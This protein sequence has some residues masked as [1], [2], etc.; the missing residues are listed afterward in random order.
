MRTQLGVLTIN[1][2]LIGAFGL[3]F[4]RIASESLSRKL[5]GRFSVPL[6]GLILASIA[7]APFFWGIAKG[8]LKGEAVRRLWLS[9]SS[10]PLLVLLMVARAA[11]FIA[12]G[13]YLASRFFPLGPGF[14]V[15]GGFIAGAVILISKNLEQVYERFVQRFLLSLSE[16]EQAEAAR[17]RPHPGES[18]TPRL[19]V[20]DGHIAVFD[21]TLDSP[22]VGRTLIELQV[23]ERF[24]A[25]VTLIE[26]EDRKLPAPSA[27]ER[28]Y[29]GDRIHAIGSDEQLAALREFLEVPPPAHEGDESGEATFSL[30]PV[31]VSNRSPFVGLSIRQCGIR[32]KARGLV[33]GVEREGHRIPNPS[34][35]FHIREGDLLWI[36]GETEKVIE[37]EGLH[38]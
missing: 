33:V 22:A 38:V 5:G 14:I 4:E 24:G 32:E 3:F 15:A 37:L 8:G 7:S 28:V 11:V 1:S 18:P 6:A 27:T 2:A 16:A 23:R 29:P 20:W 34:A 30:E 31:R 17:K 25:S 36:V 19:G 21:V 13:G 9:E 10:R 35:D 12:M 26:R